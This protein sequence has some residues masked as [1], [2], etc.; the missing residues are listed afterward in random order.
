[1]A[2]HKIPSADFLRKILSYDKETGFLTWKERPKEMFSTGYNGGE[3]QHKTWNS[4]YAGKRISNIGSGGYI[5]VNIN[6]KKFLAHRLIWRMMTGNTPSQIDHVNGDKTDNR[7]CNLREVSQAENTKNSSIRSDNTTGVTGVSFCKRDRVYIA[8]ITLN[9]R[10]KVL[11]RFSSIEEAASA[12]KAANIKYG[13]HPNHGRLTP[14]IDDEGVSSSA[15]E[16]QT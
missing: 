7:W 15:F 6:N 16:R 11:G 10:T 3:T 8:S 1:M 9:R 4:R 14:V 12:R 2:T 5:R 13:F